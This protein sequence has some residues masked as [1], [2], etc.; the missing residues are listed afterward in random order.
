MTPPRLWIDGLE[1]SISSDCD[2]WVVY[3]MPTNATCVEP[4][5]GLPDAFNMAGA[6]RLDPGEELRRSMV[7]RWSTAA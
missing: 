7:V 5:S 6:T 2:Y 4:Q 3:D 1:V